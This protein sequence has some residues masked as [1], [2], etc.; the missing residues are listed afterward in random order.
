M[1][2]KL[3]IIGL[4]AM[5]T[6]LIES[7]AE[8]GLLPT[9]S[10]LLRNGAVGE[11]QNPDRIF[12]GASWPSLFTGRNTAAHQQYLRI[13]FDEDTYG[14]TIDRPRLADAPPFWKT[15]AWENK[16]VAIMN[17]PYCPF[18]PDINGLQVADWSVHDRHEIEFSCSDAAFAAE[19]STL[20]G[21]QPCE[22][23]DNGERTPEEMV[24]FRDDLLHRIKAKTAIA[25]RIIDREDWDLFVGVIDEGHCAG[26][27]AWHLHDAESSWF[28]E[29]VY[30]QT[31]DIVLQTYRAIDAAIGRLLEKLGPEANILVMSINGMGPTYDA[32]VM[33]L[34]N[35]IKRMIGAN[36]ETRDKFKSAEAKIGRLLKVYDQMPSFV[37][38]AF[39]PLKSRFG[40]ARLQEKARASLREQ[41]IMAFPTNAQ[42]P[43]LRLNLAG[44]EASGRDQ[45]TVNEFLDKLLASLRE[46]RTEDTGELIFDRLESVSED[47]R[48]VHQGALPDYI[49]HW[50]RADMIA[51]ISPEYGRFQTD[52][53]RG[54]TGDHDIAMRGLFLGTGPGFKPIHRNAAAELE[55]IAPTI[56]RLAGLTAVPTDGN[57]LY[58][59]FSM[60][61]QR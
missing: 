25:E 57:I 51:V 1:T 27:M 3:A 56:S 43:G 29:T 42:F 54:R 2:A 50:Q 7:W 30:S 41:P 4:D 9:L 37:Q 34:N 32:N 11:L 10:R 22:V 61:V 21:A 31:G 60:G 59:I 35:L 47:I 33:M 38:A 5:E 12:S 23:C 58:D 39:K 20:V 48:A 16:R 52:L 46:L 14:I 49:V 28:D 55:D 40:R 45:I 53:V 13:L 19:I 8:Q 15:P 17:V 26:H 36:I 44:R 18:D 24:A 6:T